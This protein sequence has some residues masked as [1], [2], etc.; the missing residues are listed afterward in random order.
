MADQG[1]RLLVCGGRKFDDRELAFDELDKVL[2]SSG[3]SL[4]I[5]GGASGADALAG[6]WAASRG[7][8]VLVFKPDWRRFGRGAG[9][10]RNAEMISAGRPGLAVAF[11]GGSG[12]RDMVGRLRAAGVP[13]VEPR[14]VLP[15]QRDGVARGRRSTIAP[16][17]LRRERAV[18]SAQS[19]P[20]R[21]WP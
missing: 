21:R 8:P 10:R 13:V 20:L 17:F 9:P 6:E 7:I 14:R 4:V 16:P 18:G 3:V 2:R 1:L 11:A 15:A 12:T 19:P 5:H